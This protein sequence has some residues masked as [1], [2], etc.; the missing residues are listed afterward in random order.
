M[1]Q[2]ILVTGA[3]RGIGLEFV[4]QLLAHGARV[5]A[6][7]RQPGRALKLTE[8]AA[9]HPG[10]LH[11]LP[12]DL[13]KERSIAELA[14]ETAALTDTLD[15]LI[16]NAGI[17]LAGE[18]YGELVAKTFVD[19]FTTNVVGPLLLTQA[20]TPLLARGVAPKVV[21]LS[22][23]L[24]SLS[25][26]TAFYTPSYDISKAGMNMATRLLAAE[27]APAGIAVV[28]VNPGWVKTDM[29]GARAPLAVHDSVAAMLKL[30]DHLE[31]GASGGFFDYTGATLAW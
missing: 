6:A 17:L 16:N 3:N 13:T 10:R 12:L 26:T 18:R 23:D 4:R 1:R 30:I 9:A 29:G 22:S 11:V 27:L 14:R 15:V 31:S 19:S 24:G 21:N 20:L 2:R 5:L 7:C 28:S 8:L 25:G